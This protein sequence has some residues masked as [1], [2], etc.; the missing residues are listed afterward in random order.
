[1][2]NLKEKPFD[3]KLEKASSDSVTNL[4]ADLHVELIF[5]F[6]KISMRLLE[7]KETQSSSK[8]NSKQTSFEKEFESLLSDC[9]KNKISQALLL[10]SKAL[11]ITTN[12]NILNTDDPKILAQVKIFKY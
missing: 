2:K 6:H 12:S 4:I 5:L 10:M 3:P 11:Y 7:Y 9:K 1:L 8:P